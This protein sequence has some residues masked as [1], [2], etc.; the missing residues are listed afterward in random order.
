MHGPRALDSSTTIADLL[1]SGH[2]TPVLVMST[3]LRGVDKTADII[4]A[5]LCKRG[6]KKDDAGPRSASMIEKIGK[7]KIHA[8]VNSNNI[9]DAQ[10]K[11]GP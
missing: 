6:V 7:A 10:T 3:R 8:I 5:V 9:M 4:A 1:G 2:H 11:W